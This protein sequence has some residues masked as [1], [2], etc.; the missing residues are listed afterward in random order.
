MNNK[1]V[2]RWIELDAPYRANGNCGQIQ[3]S[4]MLHTHAGTSNLVLTA[5]H[6]THHYKAD[7]TQKPIDL[8]TGGLAHLLAEENE[9]HALIR[10]QKGP[11]NGNELV[12]AE[13][14]DHL[15]TLE[16]PI[17]LDL[18][19]AKRAAPFDLCI[20]TGYGEITH[21][22]QGLIRTVTDLAA[23][24]R[25]DLMLNHPDYAA[26]KP[27]TLVNHCQQEGLDSIIQIEINRAYR[28]PKQQPEKALACLKFFNALVKKLTA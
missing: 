19:A 17:I 18:H 6:A 11:A 9:T 20:G 13:M 22:Q 7:G 15:S 16:N 10:A 2:T 28:C 14:L 27:H 25:L 4:A 21:K 23:E 5:P 12:T 3:A 26:C 24:H 1:N 8:R